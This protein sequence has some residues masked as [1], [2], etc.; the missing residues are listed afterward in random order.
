MATV[1]ILSEWVKCDFSQRVRW[2]INLHISSPWNVPTHMSF[3]HQTVSHIISE[4]G[5]SATTFWLPPKWDWVKERERERDGWVDSSSRWCL[6]GEHM[7]WVCQ[8]THPT[9]KQTHWLSHLCCSHPIYLTSPREHPALKHV[10]FCHMMH[11]SESID[12]YIY[13][14]NWMMPYTVFCL[15]YCRHFDSA[16]IMPT[17][18]YKKHYLSFSQVLWPCPI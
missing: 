8:S 4:L 3:Y 10:Y 7:R 5:Y 12:M 6:A 17:Q 1:R 11:V 16:V 13:R 14:S 15:L 18:G 9:E 2:I